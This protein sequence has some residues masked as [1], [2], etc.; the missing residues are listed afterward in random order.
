MFVLCTHSSMFGIHSRKSSRIFKKYVD[1]LLLQQL[2]NQI[3]RN[4]KLCV[5]TSLS[6]ET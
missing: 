3:A 6:V 5:R 4:S 1:R 2:V